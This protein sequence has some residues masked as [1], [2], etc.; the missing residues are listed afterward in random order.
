[1]HTCAHGPSRIFFRKRDES[2]LVPIFNASLKLN[3]RSAVLL[4]APPL[5]LPLLLQAPKIDTRASINGGVTIR[6]PCLKATSMLSTRPLATNHPN[7]TEKCALSAPPPAFLLP[8]SFFFASKNETGAA[9]KRSLSRK[10]LEYVEISVELIRAVIRA[11]KC[12]NHSQLVIRPVNRVNCIQVVSTK[13]VR[14]N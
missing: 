6:H 13:G 9:K 4:R 3:R 8:P 2:D 10:I 7:C 11:K 1:M 5:F 14:M 12:T